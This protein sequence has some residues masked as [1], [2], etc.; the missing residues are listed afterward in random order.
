MSELRRCYGLEATTLQ[1]VVGGYLHGTWRAVTR[2]N[3]VFIK[4]Y[5]GVDWPK[6]RIL[7]TLAA[8]ERLA[9]AGL[10]VPRIIRTQT[11]ELAA[12]IGPENWSAP[13]A[14][15]VMEYLPGS[16]MAPGCLSLAACRHA[17]GILGRIHQELGQIAPGRPVLTGPDAVRREAEAVVQAVAARR[18]PDEMDRLAAEAAQYRLDALATGRLAPADYEGATWQWVHGDYYPGNWLWNEVGRITGVV[19]F[20]FCSPR[21]RGTEVGRAAVEVGLRAVGVFSRDGARAFLLGYLDANPLS[22]PEQRGIFRLWYN[23]LLSSLYPLT[24]RYQPGQRLPHGWDKLALRRHHLLL[25]LD[26]HME[27]LEGLLVGI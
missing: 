21:W 6:E 16:C 7:P 4:I 15:T 26:E 14:M 20:D 18:E 2:S 23:H 10:P 22:T 27:V 8:Q 9:E 25:W 11:G 1:P 17:G 12:A 13:V 19:D 24:L 3:L 5:T